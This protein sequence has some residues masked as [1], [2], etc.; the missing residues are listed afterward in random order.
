MLKTGRAFFDIAPAQ[1][2]DSFEF[3]QYHCRTHSCQLK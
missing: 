1:N 2:S 3:S